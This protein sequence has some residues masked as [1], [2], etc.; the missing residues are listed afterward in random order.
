[1]ADPVNVAYV[2][3]EL[4]GILNGGITKANITDAIV[5]GV[6]VMRDF[7]RLTGD[8]KKLTLLAALDALVAASSLPLAEKTDIE[9]IINTMGPKVIDS[10]IWFAT[11][12]VGQEIKNCGCFSKTT[13]PV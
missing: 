5:Q 10:L 8:Q 13:N 4:T 3:R 2:V 7:G 11:S 1:M 9:M 12:K 6:I